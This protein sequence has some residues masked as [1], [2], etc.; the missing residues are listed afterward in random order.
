[1]MLNISGLLGK[2]FVGSLLGAHRGND[3]RV[4]VSDRL[5]EIFST[6]NIGLAFLETTKNSHETVGYQQQRSTT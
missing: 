5:N 4:I 6:L 3:V 1:M 2:D